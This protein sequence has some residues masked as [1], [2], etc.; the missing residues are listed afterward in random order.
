[1]LMSIWR[2]TFV[3]FPSSL[4]LCL[5]S[6][7]GGGQSVRKRCRTAFSYWVGVIALDHNPLDL[8]EAELVAPAIVEL[9]RAR[10]GVVRHRRGLFQRAA[11]LEIGRDAG[12][13]EAVVAEF[14]CDAGTGRPPADHR[15]GVRLWQHRARELAGAAADRAEQRPLGIVAQLGAVEIGREVFL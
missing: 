14:G 2:R 4:M 11:V 3:F 12:R 13:P 8:I 15:V 5:T 1:M 9:R 6:N 7:C 10:R